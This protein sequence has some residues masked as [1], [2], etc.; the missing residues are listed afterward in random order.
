MVW[1]S[2]DCV[3]CDLSAA[4]GAEKFQLP[5]TGQIEF[6]DFESTWCAGSVAVNAFHQRSG[7]HAR[8]VTK[9]VLVPARANQ[10]QGH[11]PA[12]C[13]IYENA[14]FS[15]LGCHSG[16]HRQHGNKQCKNDKCYYRGFFHFMLP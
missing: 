4:L 8:Q 1:A 12:G 6:A 11:G 5:I 2:R 14:N 7:R 9:I 16:A 10:G 13:I 15:G 3:Q